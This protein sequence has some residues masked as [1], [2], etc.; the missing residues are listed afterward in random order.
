MEINYDFRDKTILNISDQHMPYHHP[1]MLAFLAALKAKYKPDLI[2]N[3]GDA[4]DFHNISFH[5]SDPDL[6]GANDELRKGREA[7]AKMEKL[8]PKMFIIGSNHGDLPI[9]RAVSGGLPRALFR[10]YQDIYGVGKGWRFVDDLLLVPRLGP[11]I[12][13]AHGISKNGIKLTKERSVNT[14]QFHFH[15]E[16]R[17]DYASTPTSLLWA[18]QS[19]CL[20]DTKSLAFAYDK[21]N[22]TRPI[23]GTSLV[24]NGMPRLEPMVLN[25]RGRWINKLV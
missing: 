23:I 6:L 22:L 4:L 11:S 10:P 17:I 12:Y 2:V 24:V 19:G 18:L 25:K 1:D 7:V 14:C 13:Y 5:D 21:L 3:G 16:Y 9:R 20:I 15:T 8:F